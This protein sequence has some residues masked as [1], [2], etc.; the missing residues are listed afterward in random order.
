MLVIVIGQQIQLWDAYR[1]TTELLPTRTL[2]ATLAL[3]DQLTTLES[4]KQLGTLVP[5]ARLA[6]LMLDPVLRRTNLTGLRLR[7]SVLEVSISINLMGD[8]GI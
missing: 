1:T 4:Q 7:C 6:S 2:L 3:P 5:P 8:A